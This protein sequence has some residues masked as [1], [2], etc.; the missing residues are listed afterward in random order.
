MVFS[1]FYGCLVGH[2]SLFI[3]LIG[4]A[5]TCNWAPDCSPAQTFADTLGV[6]KVNDNLNKG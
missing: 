4:I 1:Y 3:Y 6:G 2:G 5:E